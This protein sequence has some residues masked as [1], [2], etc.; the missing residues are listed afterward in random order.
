MGLIAVEQEQKCPPSSLVDAHTNTPIHKK[1]KIGQTNY[2]NSQLFNR[3][4]VFTEGVDVFPFAS[5]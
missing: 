2:A 4:D 3:G 5:S 1:C